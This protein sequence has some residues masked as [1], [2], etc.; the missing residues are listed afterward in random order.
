M[1]DYVIPPKT[2]IVKCNGC[3]TM[4]VPDRS[5][6]RR[7]RPDGSFASFEKCPIC[8]EDNNRYKDTIPLWK[9][10]LIKLFRGYGS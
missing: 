8:G 7:W 3:K 1:A 2:V 4:Y 6:D 5:K 10:N 9:Y